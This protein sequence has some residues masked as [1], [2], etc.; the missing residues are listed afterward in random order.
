MDLKNIELDTSKDLLFKEFQDFKSNFELNLK[1]RIQ[2]RLLKK[3]K[4]YFSI[5]IYTYNPKKT[6]WMPK[7]YIVNKNI[8]QMSNQT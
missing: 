8:Q 7:T 2:L 4:D 6:N 1:W 5:Y 3:Y